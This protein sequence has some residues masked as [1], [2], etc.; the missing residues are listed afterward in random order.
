MGL[1]RWISRLA[2]KEGELGMREV[3]TAPERLRV[4]CAVL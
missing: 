4:P 2:R 1:W 3:E